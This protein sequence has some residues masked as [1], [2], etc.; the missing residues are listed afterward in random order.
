MRG[1]SARK[2]YLFEASDERVGILPVEVY[3]R[4]EKSV[5]WVCERDQRPE[6]M[7]LIAL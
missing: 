1:G 4:E 6:Q 7:N 5:I 2:G 3:E